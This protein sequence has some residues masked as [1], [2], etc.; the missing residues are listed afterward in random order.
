MLKKTYN[1]KLAQA[2]WWNLLLLTIGGALYA[3]CLQCLSPQHSFLAGGVM[4]MALLANFV[5]D[6]LPVSI[7]YLVFSIP[8]YLIGWFFVSRRFLLYSLYGTM[9]TTV[10]GLL[11]NRAGYVVPVENELYAAVLG[12]VL[13]GA[14]GGIMLRSLGSGGGIDIISV[15]L[16][17]R[18][19]ISIGQF[20]LFVNLV[21]FS[22][23]LT[24]GYELDK[25]L[26]SVIMIF[27]NARMVDYVL[28]MFNNRK[29][30]LIISER[31]EEVSE[32]IMVSE[33]FGVTLLRGKGAYSGLDKDILLTVTNNMALRHL[34]NLVFTVDP[35]ALFIVENTFNVA[36]GQ[37]R[38]G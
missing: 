29:L 11:L 9:A 4:G 26:A 18:W 33:R 32:A 5:T 13:L 37:F 8:L 14:G 2:V 21:I 6:I 12:G 3:T 15:I 10:F 22:L 19:N 28:G 27:I 24:M 7:W 25:V 23:G 1:P 30:V 16:R 34:E 20:S 17:N 38:R 31:G 36:G 35:K